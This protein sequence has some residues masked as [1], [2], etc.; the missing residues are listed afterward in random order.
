MSDTASTVR[1]LL[2]L[3]TS[4]A[5]NAIAAYEATGHGLPGPNSLH[6]LDSAPDALALKKAVRVLEGACD[7]LCWTLSPPMHTIVNV[8]SPL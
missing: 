2:A 4:A 6:P 8:C 1:A 7:Q 5:D 3:I